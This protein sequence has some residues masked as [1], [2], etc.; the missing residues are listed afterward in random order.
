MRAVLH[1]SV[2]FLDS[3]FRIWQSKAARMG[4]QLVK[5][6]SLLLPGVP[7][8]LLSVPVLVP[9]PNDSSRTPL[10]ATLPR[11]YRCAKCPFV[12]CLS[13]CSTLPKYP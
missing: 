10:S 5:V 4:M 7:L 8:I 9:V 11:P 1:P 13:V 6:L 3:R 12:R 2:A